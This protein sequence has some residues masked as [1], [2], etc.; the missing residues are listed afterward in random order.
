MNTPKKHNAFISYSRRDEIIA[1]RLEK[2]LERYKIPDAFQSL[3]QKKFSIFRDVHDIELGELSEQLREGLDQSDFLIVLCSPNSY[4]STYVGEEIKYF[5]E[6][7]GKEKILPVLVGGRP[8]HEVKK[9]DPNQD[10]AFHEV[11]FQFFKEPLAADFREIKGEGYFKK[12]A[13]IREGR[14]QIISRLLY[15]TKTNELVGRYV[16]AKRITTGVLGFACLLLFT[17]LS[18]RYYDNIPKGGISFTAQ[19]S[20]PEQ[21]TRTHK[22]LK[23]LNQEIKDQLPKKSNK[24]NLLLATWNIKELGGARYGGRSEEAL[25]YIAE[26]ISHFDIVAVQEVKEDLRPLEQV[27]GYL[28]KHWEKKFTGV[29]DGNSGNNER[30]GFIYDNRKIQLGDMTDQIVLRED[31][32]T[33][34]LITR[35]IARTPYLAEFI[36]NESSIHFC[37]VHFYFGAQDGPRLQRR[38][39]EIRNTTAYLIKRLED[40]SNPMSHM[41]LLGDMNVVKLDHQTMTVLKESGFFVPDISINKPT[42]IFKERY[43]DQIA[44]ATKNENFKFNILSGGSLDFFQF[45]YRDEDLPIYEP[46]FSESYRAGR[47][48]ETTEKKSKYY[49]IW[50]SHQM[51]DHLV[52]WI[53]LSL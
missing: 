8:N 24:N 19:T 11:L 25:A 16:L 52:K 33:D 22:N 29:T 13:R 10:Q 4:K 41:V 18:W 2:F 21:K 3:N 42:S 48:P 28:G 20:I 49:K 34:S 51:S 7:K 32:R 43:Y 14:F 1:K 9:D 27:M 17:F 39:D 40:K 26:V 50:K 23:L 53:E 5:G 31:K 36:F 6:K 47:A 35:Q 37:N 38:L 44:F 45:V 46:V 15:T 30:L 12:K